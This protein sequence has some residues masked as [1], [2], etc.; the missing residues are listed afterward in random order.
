MQSYCKVIGL[1]RIHN[2]MFLAR[3]VVL[4]NLATL[5]IAVYSENGTVLLGHRVLPVEGLRPGVFCIAYRSAKWNYSKKN[6]RHKQCIIQCNFCYFLT[7]M[8]TTYGEPNMH[9]F[10]PNSKLSL[11]L[12]SFACRVPTHRTSQRV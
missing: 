8:Y 2:G 3:Q 1:R 9:S 4:P 7:I 6:Q 10:D 11:A 12:R 5:R